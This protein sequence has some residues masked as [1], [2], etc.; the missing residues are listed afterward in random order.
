MNTV[1]RHQDGSNPERSL[2][3][4]AGLDR[5]GSGSVQLAG[6]LA[7]CLQFCLCT[8]A[9]AQSRFATSD[10][11]SGYVHWID[12]YDAQNTR[13]DPSSERPQP[14]SPAKTC[15]RC[16]DYEQIVHGWHFNSTLDGVEHGRPGQ[17]WIWSDPRSGT[18]LPLSYRKWPGSFD[19]DALG[20]TRWQVAEKLGG[21]L[22]GGGPGSE[23]SLAVALPPGSVAEN[24]QAEDKRKVTGPLPVDCMMCHHARGSGYSPFAWTENIEDQNFAYAPTA[25][26]GI[27]IIDGSLRRLKEDFDVNAEGA[28]DKL[29]KVVYEQARFRGDGKVFFD[30]VRKPTN[31]AC[32]YCHTNVSADIATGGRWLHDEDIHLRA[33]MQCADCHRNG[34]DHHTVRGFEGEQHP[35]G[36]AIASLS[37]VGCHMPGPSA[38]VASAEAGRLGAPQPM[39]AGLPA[40]HFDKLSC[41][42]CHSG[43]AASDSLGR[44]LNSI[45][46]RLGSHEKRTGNEFPGII[47]A[48]SLPVSPSG[49][50]GV[51][52]GAGK[53]TPHRLMWPSYWATIQDKRV[54]PLNPN[55]A[56]ELVRRPLKVKREFTEDLAEVKLALSTRSELI[57]EE[58]ARLKP[59][60]WTEEEQAKIAQ[61]ESEARRLQVAERIA[62]ALEAIEAEYPNSQALWISGGAGFVRDGEQ[63]I[64]SVDV[65]LLGDAGKPYA[66]P[67]AHNVRP[68]RQ[69]LGVNGCVECHSQSSQFFGATIQPIGL[70]PDQV[71]TTL[72]AHELQQADMQRLETWNQMFVGRSLFKILGL[73][74]LGLTSLLTLSALAWNIGNCCRR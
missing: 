54:K 6:W 50:H 61:A 59:E 21:F 4:V 73:I 37:C 13:I 7:M 47:A 25:A 74:A 33:G 44:Q 5:P 69:A 29:P 72:K 68:A 27:A 62:A 32:Y 9:S 22:P 1:P 51:D 16:H 23:E 66:W 31:D 17:P 18:H 11:M 20:L 65:D 45:A 56:Y 28:A 43:P 30:L 46:H 63:A 24:A 52:A 40:L 60:E 48:V 3:T 15:G 57:G 39:H 49:A 64:K 38:G 53:Y 55:E 67:L 42:A 58:R 2:A 14:Y 36:S 70:L 10:N 8:I 26:M 71:T 19:P 34:L 12:L 35:A 41:T